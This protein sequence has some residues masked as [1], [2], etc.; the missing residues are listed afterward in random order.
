MTIVFLGK[1]IGL[2]FVAIS[3]AMLVNRQRTLD[4]FDAMAASP[5]WMLFSG[6]VATAVGLALAADLETNGFG[7][8]YSLY[9][10]RHF[11]AVQC[12]IKGNGVFEVARNMGTSVEILQKYYGKSATSAKFA[13]GLGD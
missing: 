8:R 5:A 3:L 12:L 13:T 4:T 1:L 6:M 10:L 11:Y 7:E 2:Y 9:S